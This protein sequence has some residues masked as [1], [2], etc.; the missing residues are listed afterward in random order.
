MVTV[1]EPAFDVAPCCA[2]SLFPALR[3][4]D[5][6]LFQIPVVSLEGADDAAS[7]PLGALCDVDALAA[8]G[9]LKAEVLVASKAS[10]CLTA[11]TMF[12]AWPIRDSESKYRL[13]AS[14]DA[15]SGDFGLYE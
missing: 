7:A 14:S 1:S 11:S 6:R 13:K 10:R 3:I 9:E 2:C 12:R 8:G 4:R 5:T 15:K